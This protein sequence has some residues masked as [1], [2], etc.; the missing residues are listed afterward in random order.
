MEKELIE[1][2]KEAVAAYEQHNLFLDPTTALEQSCKA[3]LEYRGFSVV[4]PDKFLGPKVKDLKDLI[5]LFYS[6]LD[7]KVNGTNYAH[8]FRNSMAQDMAIAKRFVN[9]RMEVN[10]V[11]KEVALKECAQ[12]INVVF[13]RYDEFNFKYDIS[14]SIFGLGKMA[15]V[16][17]HAVRI[18]NTKFRE[19]NEAEAEALRQAAMAAQDKSQLGW[20]L[21]EILKQIEEDDKKNGN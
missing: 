14:F 5:S 13:D 21:D 6:R 3:Y 9:S 18:L 17:E 10:G 16:T 15:W 12:I 19:K 4:K 11:C 7:K 20:D 8:S 1:K 2:I